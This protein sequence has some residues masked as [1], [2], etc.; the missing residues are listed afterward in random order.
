M[1]PIHAEKAI[2]RVSGRHAAVPHTCAACGDLSRLKGLVGPMVRGAVPHTPERSVRCAS[3]SADSLERGSSGSAHRAVRAEQ[4]VYGR[5]HTMNPSAPTAEAVA[6]RDERIIAV[7]SRSE[8][9]GLADRHTEV[10][11]FGPQIVM[12]GFVEPHMHYW[13]TALF[14]NWVDLSVGVGD[15]KAGVRSVEEI[16]HRLKSAPPTRGE[17]TLGCQFDPSLLPAGSELTRDLLDQ[18]IPDR[19]VAVLNASM[20]FLYVNSKA[21]ELAGIDDSVADPDGG[22]FGRTG[23]R[24][25]GAVGEIGAMGQLIAVIPMLDQQGLTNNLVAIARRAR[26]AGV[27]TTHDA[28]TGSILGVA[29]ADLFAAHV[30]QM[31]TRVSYAVI[32]SAIDAFLAHGIR[33]FTGSD[34]LRATSWKLIS[35]GSNQGK[36]G[37]QVEPYKGTDSL[38]HPNFT[39]EFAAERIRRASE[40]GWQVMVHANGDEAIELAV[41]AYEDA[42]G[43]GGAPQLRHRIEHCSFATDDQLRRMA[44]LRVSPSFLINHVYYWG[45]AFAESIVGPKKAARLDPVASALRHGLTPSFHSDYRVTDFEPLRMVQTAVTRKVAD[46]GSV[47]GPEERVNL[48]DGF[49]AVT[50]G[51][52]WQLHAENSV[53]SIRPGAFGD[54]VVLEQDPFTVGPDSIVEAK[55]LTTLLG[56]R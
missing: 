23:G 48:H 11:D 47:L 33:P 49:A 32:D 53:G 25:N 7:G 10:H 54:L 44:S 8:V 27:T 34:R 13:A 12:P 41:G 29:E 52:A 3:A 36:S 31:G 30:D 37:F 21:F 9:D 14:Y 51:A 20:H 40:L 15:A 18:A 50:T 46:G 39:R 2:E 17:W 22:F 45:R 6:I 38:G 1:E 24:L 55:V 42:L 35:D 56:G 43:P 5:V 26:A 4:I 16:I 19:P 28:A